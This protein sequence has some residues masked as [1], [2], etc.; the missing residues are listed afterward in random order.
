MHKQEPFY[1]GQY[2]DEIINV[3]TDTPAAWLDIGKHR[4]LYSAKKTKIRNSEKAQVV[5][6][7][8]RPCEKPKALQLTF[9]K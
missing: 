5:S 8:R 9:N 7:T 6:N 2:N 4:R 1:P 3:Q